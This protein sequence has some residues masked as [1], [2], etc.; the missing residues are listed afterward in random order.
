MQEF[1]LNYM[2]EAH[3]GQKIDVVENF[4]VLECWECGF[5]HLDPIPSKIALD[6]FYSQQYYQV[7]KSSYIQQDEKD[8]KYLEISYEERLKVFE[9]LTSGRRILDVGCGSGM[10]L[11][12][13]ASLNWEC[14]G[15]EPSASA[16][17]VARAKGLDIFHG[18]FDKFFREDKTIYDVIYLKNV[19]EHVAD[20]FG[21]LGQCAKRI[22]AQGI[23]FVEVP[24]DYELMQKVGIALL[25]EKKSWISVPDHINYF[26]FRS[27]RELLYRV[28]LKPVLRSTT[29]PI[30]ACLLFGCNFIS[31]KKAGLRAHSLRVS[32]EIYCERLHMRWFKHFVYKV[33]A[34][35]G[36]GRTVIYYCRLEN[37]KRMSK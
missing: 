5:K 8:K 15:V 2:N 14:R 19:L 27:L 17:E 28:N 6:H 34:M 24:N 29:F 11:F 30:Y 26:N 3:V 20:P 1:F 36:V 18:S 4:S 21:L 23:L 37:N 13:A 22:S 25:K 12:Y 7:H 33:M 9:R 16:V 32:F 35:M 10:F 31:D